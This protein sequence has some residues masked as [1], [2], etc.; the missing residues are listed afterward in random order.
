MMEKLW[1]HDGTLHD[2]SDGHSDRTNNGSM[3]ARK[4]KNDGTSGEGSDGKTGC[5]TDPGNDGR[6]LENIE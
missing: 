4:S 6:V 5:Q 1:Q 3:C 2:K